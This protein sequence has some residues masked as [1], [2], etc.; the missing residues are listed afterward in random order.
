MFMEYKIVSACFSAQS[1]SVVYY[2]KTAVMTPQRV[3]WVDKTTIMWVSAERVI[4]NQGARLIS[5][6][7]LA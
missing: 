6:Q 4:S 1:S 5:P 2:L 3:V 7:A